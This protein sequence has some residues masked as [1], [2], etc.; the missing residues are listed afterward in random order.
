VPTTIRDLQQQRAQRAAQ[1][2]AL[3]DEAQE[4]G[5][6]LTGEESATFDRLMNEA[7]GF[8]QQA[9]RMQRAD[10]HAQLD[11]GLDEDGDGGDQDGQRGGRGRGRENEGDAQT[12][13]FRAY[14]RGGM[15][16]LDENQVRSLQMSN[17]PDGGYLMAPQQFVE[18]LIQGVDDDVHV[19]RLATV[20]TLTTAESLG[21]PSL[22]EDLADADWTSELETG[23]EDD[24]IKFGKR[25][26][27]PNP[28]AKLVK[29]SRTLMRRATMSPEALVQ[30][31]MRYK[32]AATA[33]KAYMVG[34]GNKKP[35]GVFTASAQGIST[36]RDVTIGA[37]GAIPLTVAT[38]D[39]LIDAKY[40]LKAAY[41]RDARW[42]F[43]RDVVKVIRKVKDSDGQYI[44]RPG[45]RDDMNDLIVELP[46][47]LSEF[48][49]NTI[50]ADGYV[51][52][53]GDWSYYWI[54]DSLAMEIQRLNELYARTNQFGYIGR[55]ESDG[56]PVLEE[57][58]IRLKVAA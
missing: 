13:A 30:N 12:Q 54:V 14:L 26:F 5:R 40:S 16:A 10:R 45:L 51:G 27:R 15:G 11:A 3:L 21:V 20:Q 4:A 57:A 44:W 23:S 7:D 18:Q 50:A 8:Q 36:S 53:L 58:F 34:D 9:E 46:F 41:Y 56:M 24:G 33:E 22:D 39:Q 29:I 17:N 25:E 6:D 48:A 35:L 52:I 49:P 38:A 31:R 37:A 43:H 42:M 55:L 28:L 1:A 2:R 47:E 19:R 32:F